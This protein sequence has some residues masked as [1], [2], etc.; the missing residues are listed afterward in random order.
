MKMDETDY[1]WRGTETFSKDFDGVCGRISNHG[2]VEMGWLDGL[3]KTRRGTRTF[4]TRHVARH[5]QIF[6][7]LDYDSC[8]RRNANT[9]ERTWKHDT[10]SDVCLT[11]P[12]FTCEMKTFASTGAQ[13][14]ALSKASW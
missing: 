11:N 5:H 12:M 2:L 6:A 1:S 4:E 10:D 7:Y 3:D 8:E 14:P 9:T 13:Y